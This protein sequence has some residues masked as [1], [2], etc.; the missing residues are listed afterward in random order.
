MKTYEQMARAVLQKI[1]IENEKK[2]HR[3]Q[4]LVRST[5]AVCC[6]VL[7]VLVGVGVPSLMSKESTIS[8]DES[9]KP[10]ATSV[11]QIA[12]LSE[13]GW[14]RSVMK[15]QI[16]TQM[17][18][19]L[20][21]TD[22]RGLTASQREVLRQEKLEQMH[23]ELSGYYSEYREGSGSVNNAWDN[24]LFTMLRVGSFQLELN[25]EKA[26][27]SIR[28]Q[29]SS[30][31]S[32]VEFGIHSKNLVGQKVAYQAKWYDGTEQRTEKETRNGNVYLHAMSVTLDGTTYDRI[33]QDGYFYIRWKPSSKLYETINDNPN[34]PL[35][36]FSDQMTIT[37]NYTD[38]SRDNHKIDIVFH[39]DGNIGAVYHVETTAE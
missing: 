34:R 38:G 27:E 2:R 28:A 33:Q 9:V 4:R 18:Y 8:S 10:V 15:E 25:E 5:V 39:D 30:I 35:S 29:C 37:V 20:S 31:Y 13:N 1:E 32:E 12:Y 23:Q 16:E 17:R 36:E 14:D 24:A 22:V 21:V 11:L 7:T 6:A 26:V 19:R 3:Q